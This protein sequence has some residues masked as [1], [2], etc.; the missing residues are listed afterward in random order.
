MIA[1]FKTV[2][3][4]RIT[5][6]NNLQGTI[7]IPS[8]DL[9]LGVQ[10]RVHGT[11]ANGPPASVDQ[12]GDLNLLDY[13]RFKCNNKN[14]FDLPPREQFQ[15]ATYQWGTA[16]QRTAVTTTVGAFYHDLYFPVALPRPAK[17]PD[18][19]MTGAPLGLVASPVLEYRVT[20]DMI[21]ALFGTPGTTSFS[22]GPIM[23]VTL[24][25]LEA[26]NDHLRG[27]VNAGKLKGYIQNYQE[28]T[29]S[30]SGNLEFELESGKGRLIDLYARAIDNG[31]PDE[32]H[33]SNVT[34][35]LGT[36]DRPLESRHEVLQADAKRFFQCETAP[37]GTWMYPFNRNGKNNQF[38]DLNGQRNVRVRYNCGAPTGTSQIREIQGT[39]IDDFWGGDVS[40]S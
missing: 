32:D 11:T 12:D 27:L 22:V 33:V 24:H 21:N 31:V 3:I 23:Q 4:D 34:L 28:K 1:K 17:Y 25:L 5:L 39:L 29:V 37:A 40:L 26:S 19:L 13:F 15:R 7:R 18:Y 16:P 6:T 35:L 8:Q 2:D 36:N 20:S 14:V 9:L 30:G 38:V 10:V